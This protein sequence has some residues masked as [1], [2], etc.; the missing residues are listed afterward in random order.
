MR[1]FLILLL[2]SISFQQI[3]AQRLND[4]K[5]E[6]GRASC[7]FGEFGGNGLVFSANYDTRFK[8][9]QSGPGGRIGIG[10]FGGDGGGIVTFPIGLNF[11][12]GRNGNYFETGLGITI[13]TITGSDFGGIT[14]SVIVPS[15]G[16][17]YQSMT[18]GF[19]GR[20][21]I[22]PLIGT[23]GG[24]AFWAGISAGYKF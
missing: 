9:S 2:A 6:S 12:N 3:T 16:Y 22:T 17:R 14:G 15:V 24:F 8:Q 19:T 5:P 21:A 7:V 10:F 18:E 11:L 13:V 1:S 20:V 23:S 4:P